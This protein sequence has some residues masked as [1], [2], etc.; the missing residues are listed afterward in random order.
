MSLIKTVT[1]IA[2][3]ILSNSE[4]SSFILVKK[5]ELLLYVQGLIKTESTEQLKTP[6]RQSAMNACM[7]LV[8]LNPPINEADTSELI[9]ICLKSVF[10]LVPLG[11]DKYKEDGNLDMMARELL[12]TET[13]TT[14][15]SFLKQ[16]LLLDLS[17]GGLQAMFNHIEGWIT[18]TKDYERERA[19]DITSKLLRFYLEELNVRNVVAFHNLGSLIGRLV[20]RCLDPLLTTQ[21]MAMDCLYILLYIQLCYEGFDLD[22]K[23]ELVEHLKTIRQQLDATNGGPVLF[24]ACCEI[25]EVISKRLPHDQ[26]SNLIFMLLNGLGDQH[27]S[28]ASAAAIVMDIV[29]KRRGS[30]LRDQV[31]EIL[32]VL[33]VQMHAIT[34]K[35]V[36]LSV[37]HSIAI[38]ASQNMPAVL[39][40]L[41]TYPLP[42]NK[43][44]SDIWKS[45]AEDTSLATSTI[46]HLHIAFE[47]L[48][49]TCALREILSKPE[50]AE[51]VNKLYAQLFSSLIVHL[52]SCINVRVSKD[53]LCKPLPKEPNDSDQVTTAKSRDVC[54]YSVETLIAML[55][56]GENEEVVNYM[57][58]K[59]GWD[60][61][62]DPH[63]YHKGVILL[64]R[65][66]AKYAAPHLVGIVEQLAPAIL[67][68]QENQ[69]VTVAAFFGELLK[70]HVVSHLQLTFV[71]VSSLLRCLFYTPPV[72]RLLSIRGLG[73]VAIG[74]PH[75]IDK[76]G[77]KLLC[78]M[79]AVMDE[80]DDPND[81]IMLEV[82]CCLTK[83]LQQL[84]PNTVRPVLI[85]IA[86]GV[87]NF[88]E[89]DNE[90]VRAAAYTVF[91]N[92]AR[93]GDGHAKASFLEQIHLS[94]VSLLVHLNESGD[95][96]VKACKLTLRLVVPLMGSESMSMNAHKYL[97]GDILNY[98]EFMKDTSK[99]LVKDFPDMINSYVTGCTLYF[100]RPQPEIRANAVMFS[101]F[102]PRHKHSTHS[103][104][105]P[106][107]VSKFIEATVNTLFFQMVFAFF[108]LVKQNPWRAHG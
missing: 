56:Q 45:L 23:D 105:L 65:A 42:L 38:L 25:A 7:H 91:G 88:F 63:K 19:M 22:Q 102:C 32:K 13:I 54:I 46:K 44:T 33:Q 29:I 2:R 72:V 53:L 62:I 95:E 31:S 81:F 51:A 26:L 49:V 96:V 28:C 37:I 36:R 50:S 77:T 80:K 55:N 70:H 76:Y 1:L 10:N 99:Q 92:L 3:A 100:K 104:C 21:Q 27:P 48:A 60:L 58:E 85:K 6:L 68:I 86:L 34:E 74:V 15:Q 67:N 66:M 82:M 84:E 41:L 20:P 40:C 30:G 16:I 69:K 57:K 87:Q 83:L 5:R 64:A 75:N 17:P 39:N 73:N 4:R 59:G 11:L 98:G 108:Y 12:Y 89:T 90:K 106:V 107:L 78:A 101:G 43:Y 35:A 9:K 103:R 18:S 52:S 71:L 14:L 24:K 61:M 94:L 97:M 8:Q 79:I 47:P 93:F